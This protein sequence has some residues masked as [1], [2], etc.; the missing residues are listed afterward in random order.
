MDFLHRW[1]LLTNL[2]QYLNL[3]LHAHQIFQAELH[4]NI[5]GQFQQVI[6]LHSLNQCPLSKTQ[7]NLLLKAWLLP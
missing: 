5:K 4:H 6:I 7:E 1:S 2:I 3:A